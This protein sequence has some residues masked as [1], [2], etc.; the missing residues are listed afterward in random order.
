MHHFDIVKSFNLFAIIFGYEVAV[1]K[2][3]MH[4]YN[5]VNTCVKPGIID[6]GRRS[7]QSQQLI[8]FISLKRFMG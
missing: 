2:G 1:D 5:V 6:D 3:L 4:V 8:S 7:V